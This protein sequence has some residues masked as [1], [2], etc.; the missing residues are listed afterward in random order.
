MSGRALSTCGSG[1]PTTVSGREIARTRREDCPNHRRC[2]VQSKVR[3]FDKSPGN[4]VLEPQSAASPFRCP[5]TTSSND[6]TGVANR[7]STCTISPF[8][9][10]CRN[11]C[12]CLSVT[13]RDSDG[14]ARQSAVSE[15]DRCREDG[16]KAKSQWMNQ[17]P[18]DEPAKG[19]VS[20]QRIGSYRILQPWRGG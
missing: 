3:G 2:R 5:A 13:C 16:P 9:R 12:G 7:S 19:T 15:V 8:L 14:E 18:G 4:G 11:W 1:H 10:G 17:L 6:L 20:D